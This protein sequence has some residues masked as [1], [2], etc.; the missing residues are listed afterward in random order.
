M[1][2]N[3]FF[4]AHIGLFYKGGKMNHLDIN[5]SKEADEKVCD[6][7]GEKIKLKAEICPHCGVR[8]KKPINKATLLLLT[9]FLGGI[10]AHKFYIKKNGQGLLYLIFCWTW[11]PAIIALI[12]F[13]I[14]ALADREEL[15]K[16]Y[17]EGAGGGTLIGILVGGCVFFIFLGILAAIVIPK[18]AAHKKIQEYNSIAEAAVKNAYT[19][20]VVYCITDNPGGI[21]SKEALNQ[22]GYNSS[23]D[24]E[25]NILDGKLDSL[26]IVAYHKKGSIWYA[27]D[28]N[29]RITNFFGGDSSKK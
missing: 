28:S 18:Y 25:I 3:C 16:K 1:K 21:F 7:C 29:G 4:S 17:P 11:I 27:V 13:F 20:A 22:Y 19:A 12:E 15:Q 8:Q 2:A 9:L 24:V 10:G 26:S 14:F 5:K 6:S 23:Q